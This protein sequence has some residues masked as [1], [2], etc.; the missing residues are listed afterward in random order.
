M[1][2]KS[3]VLVEIESLDPETDFERSSFLS[4]SH[5]FPW[6]VEQSLSLAFFKTYGIASISALLHRTAGF[7]VRPQKRYDDT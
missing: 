7:Q 5:D 6:D 3:R 2:R 1:D 4:A